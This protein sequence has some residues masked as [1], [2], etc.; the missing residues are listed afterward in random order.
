MKL[1]HTP[2][3][4]R[5]KTLA[6]S[7]EVRYRTEDN[8]M[9]IYDAHGSKQD[10]RKCYVNGL[11]MAAFDF[12]RGNGYGIELECPE[13]EAFVEQHKQYK[14]YTVAALRAQPRHPITLEKYAGSLDDL[15]KDVTQMRY[16]V[17]AKL[18]GSVAGNMHA[19][20][21]ADRTRGREQLATKLER[22]AHALDEAKEEMDAAWEICKPYMK[23][24]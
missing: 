19:D 21:K 14:K 8:V 10:R 18:F 2:G 23:K 4:F 1:E 17:V 15:A 22:I 5:T 12:A 13:A 20:A 7:A 3:I 11:L 24:E 6:G 9:H 16:D